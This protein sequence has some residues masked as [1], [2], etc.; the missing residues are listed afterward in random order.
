MTKTYKL[1]LCTVDIFQILDALNSRAASYQQTAC[2][3]AGECETDEL[4]LT[5][6]C[7]DAIEAEEIAQHHRD[8]VK[9]IENQIKG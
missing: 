1:T 3:I 5:E 9:T 2:V 8:I 4:F 7:R 6:E